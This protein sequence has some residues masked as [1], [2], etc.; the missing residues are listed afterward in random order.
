LILQELDVVL[1]RLWAGPPREKE[2]SLLGRLL[3]PFGVIYRWRAAMALALDSL[4]EPP[5]FPAGYSVISWDPV[6]LGRL[7][8]IDRLSYAGTIDAALYSGYFRSAAGSRRLWEEAL[9]GRFGRFDPERTL[10]LMRQGEPRGHLMAS[11]RSPREGF[12]GNLAVLPEDRGGTGRALLLESLWRYRRAGFQWVTLAV[13]LENERALRLY[14]S[15]GFTMRYKFPVMAWHRP[16]GARRP[17]S[18]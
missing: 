7:G 16:T 1:P 13:T 6:W 2:P 15:L 3:A 8:E 9:R 17:A 12:I 14:Q 11:I 5:R 10:L 18:G 4:S